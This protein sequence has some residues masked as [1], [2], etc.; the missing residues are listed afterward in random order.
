M[1]PSIARHVGSL[2]LAAHTLVGDMHRLS[3]ETPAVH[4]HVLGLV[5]A[6][7]RR[8]ERAIEFAIAGVAD[9]SS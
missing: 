9:D 8:F 1:I 2:A 5:L 7:R 6:G 4:L 3:A